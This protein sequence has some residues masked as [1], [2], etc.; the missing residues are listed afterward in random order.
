LK[1][2]AGPALIPDHPLRWRVIV[3]CIYDKDQSKSA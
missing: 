3:N 2:Y 1:T